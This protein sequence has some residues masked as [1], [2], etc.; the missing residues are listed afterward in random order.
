M[1]S[2]T[3]DYQV[4]PAQFKPTCPYGTRVDYALLSRAG[5]ASSQ[6]AVCHS[7]ITDIVVS[8]HAAV[9]LDLCKK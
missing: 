1:R 3:Q 8:D 6:W 7:E 2:L 5:L 9:V 4:F